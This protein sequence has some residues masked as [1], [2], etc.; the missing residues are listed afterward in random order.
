MKKKKA[1][2]PLVSTLEIRQVNKGDIDENFTHM[3]NI[4]WEYILLYVCFSEMAPI[5]MKA[6]NDITIFH[7]LSFFYILF[8]LYSLSALSGPY[9]YMCIMKENGVITILHFLSFLLSFIYYLSALPG[10]EEPTPGGSEN[11]PSHHKRVAK[12]FPEVEGR[13]LVKK[14]TIAVEDLST[15]NGLYWCMAWLKQS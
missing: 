9:I 14:S 7:F 4:A 10:D 5:C 13:Y 12:D 2:L 11:D 6:N 8:L 15:K 3:A 1:L